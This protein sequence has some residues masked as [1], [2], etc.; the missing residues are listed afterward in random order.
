MKLK[1]LLPLLIL[2]LAVSFASCKKG[3]EK[4]IVKTW[5]VTSVMSKGTVNDSI[6]QVLKADLMKAEMAFK[7]NKYTMTSDG[8][9][10]ESGTYTFKN[11]KLV[12]KTEKGMNM[13]AVVTKDNLTLDTPDFM[14]TL[15][16]K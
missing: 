5:K 15:Q 1:T 10:I 16:P 12:V 7:D 9:V 8:N 6:F 13:D 4:L 2:A 3:P 14:T 11:G